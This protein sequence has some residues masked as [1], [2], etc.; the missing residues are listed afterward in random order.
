MRIEIMNEGK[1][2]IRIK[3]RTKEQN[4]IFS[5]SLSSGQN[6]QADGNVYNQTSCRGGKIYKLH[7][8]ELSNLFKDIS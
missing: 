5:T 4:I 7:Q 2:Q 8:T 6:P 1:R 3:R